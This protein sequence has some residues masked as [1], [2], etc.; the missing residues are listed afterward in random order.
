MKKA[1]LKRINAENI[2]EEELKKLVI[3]SMISA[4]E[5]E[6]DFDYGKLS[7]EF[8]EKICTDDFLTGDEAQNLLALIS[9]VSQGMLIKMMMKIGI[10]NKEDVE[11][12]LNEIEGRDGNE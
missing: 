11:R 8:Y 1:I 2:S 9:L 3:T 5:A 12:V 4:L 10:F 6:K 7:K